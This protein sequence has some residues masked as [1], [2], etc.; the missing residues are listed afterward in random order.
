MES[1]TEYFVQKLDY[2]QGIP[3]LKNLVADSL[4]PTFLDQVWK[5]LAFRAICW[6]IVPK[7]TK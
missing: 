1:K 3:L 5:G 2:F 6:L 4:L 7:L